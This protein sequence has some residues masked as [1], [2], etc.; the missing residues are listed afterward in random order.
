MN[1]S[2]RPDIAVV[3]GAFGRTTFLARAVASV[4]AQT[5]SRDRI[6]I[7]VTKDFTDPALD[8]SLAASGVLTIQDAEPR[9]GRWL[10]RA[11]RA[12]HAP[13]IAFLDDDDE[14]VPERLA[15]VVARFRDDPE[16]G[17]YRNRVQV[18]DADGRATDPAGWRRLE[19]D[20]G[21]DRTG[22]VA[23][24]PR[25]KGGMLGLVAHETHAG[26]NSSTIV[27]RR[28]LFDGELGAAFEGTQLPDVALLVAAVV[29]PF[30]L[31]LDDRRLTRF[32]YH[33]ENITH[34]VAWLRHAAEAHAALADLT[35]R[36]GR[37]DFAGWL[38]GVSEHYDRV[39][40]ATVLITEV[41][42]GAS[43]DRVA[44]LA[45]DYLRFL[46][47]HRAERRADAEVWGPTLYALAYL[48]WPGL[49]Q[50]VA[51]ARVPVR[52]A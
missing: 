29:S 18:I 44:S 51:V 46:G 39:Y 41:R 7:V 32:R 11:I 38:R 42:A 30:G 12:T 48:L 16:L 34:S 26:F 24:P 8:R 47:C 45:F 17:F 52:R 35:G 27:V 37:D 22:P 5:L 6:E 31:Y 36:H 23:V 28:E 3:I 1:R 15:G 33:G 9:I 10:L 25:A 49:G 20:V 19:K 21:F 14:F 40:R 50:R 4:L 2:N 43:R 13:L